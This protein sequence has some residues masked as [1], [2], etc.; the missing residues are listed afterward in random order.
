MSV[1]HSPAPRPRVSPIPLHA[2]FKLESKSCDR[3]LILVFSVL[4]S[5]V[6]LLKSCDRL[7]NSVDRVLILV[8]SALQSCVCLLKSCDRLLNSV[9]RVLILV[10]SANK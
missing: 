6:C 10:F 8:F 5:C 7:L 4:Q 2:F 3:F 1:T 9:D